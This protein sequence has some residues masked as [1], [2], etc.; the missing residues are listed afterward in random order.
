MGDVMA[1]DFMLL[2]RDFIWL[3]QSDSTRQLTLH[4]YFEEL[5][6]CD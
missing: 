2:G 3:D 6:L 1:G 5:G 4:K